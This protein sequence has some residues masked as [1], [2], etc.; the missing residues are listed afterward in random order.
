MAARSP[1]PANRCAKP[2][3]LSAS[4]AGRR[5]VSMSASTSM[6]AESRAPGVMGLSCADLL[7]MASVAR[8]VTSSP[9]VPAEAGTQ[10]LRDTVLGAAG[11]PLPRG[12]TGGEDGAPRPSNAKLV[13]AAYC[14]HGEVGIGQEIVADRALLLEQIEP[15]G[16]F[17]AL[18]HGD[19]VE[20]RIDA[21]QLLDVLLELVNALDRETDMIHAGRQER[22]A[23]IVLDPPRHDHERHVA[24]RGIV[25]G[26]ARSGAMAG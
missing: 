3:S 12:R 18:A 24:A 19:R 23:E 2:Q 6:A 8:P 11:S 14:D 13:P 4:G 10:S 21:D 16:A 1:E 20:H 9:F 17:L 25:A 7:A 15:R 26:I 5:R 22:G